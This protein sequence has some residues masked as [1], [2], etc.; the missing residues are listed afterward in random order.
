MA[1]YRDFRCR[2]VN[3]ATPELDTA[4]LLERIYDPTWNK[5]IDNEGIVDGYRI[6]R[7]E[8]LAEICDE[9]MTKLYE[10]VVYNEVQKYC[11][12][13]F[14]CFGRLTEKIGDLP[15]IAIELTDYWVNVFP[16]GSYQRIHSHYNSNLSGVVYLQV[17]EN[18]G[19]TYI[20][21]PYI[22][23]IENIITTASEYVIQPFAKTGLLYPSSLP[24]SISR[25]ESDDDKVSISY[26]L[27]LKNV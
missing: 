23:G 4:K 21:S 24:Q 11:M 22:N 12:D 27:K 19:D 2:I 3:Y 26:T 20:P 8:N 15:R 17:P 16:P 10:G 7:N 6:R 25:N 18:S 13:E 9:E 14:H 1:S 5:L